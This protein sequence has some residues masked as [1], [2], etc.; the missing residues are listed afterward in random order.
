MIKRSDSAKEKKL[1]KLK[2]VGVKKSKKKEKPS[3]SIES[4]TSQRVTRS[5][6]TVHLDAPRVCSAKN[7]ETA[8][9]SVTKIVEREKYLTRSSKV[10]DELTQSNEINSSQNSNVVTDSLKKNTEKR[11]VKRENFV[12]L[13]NFEEDSFCL[14]K[15][16]F[17][18]PWP[19]RVL[20]IEKKKNFGAFLWRQT[21][22]LR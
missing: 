4:I 10:S 11:I 22:W 18:I 14:A 21:S 17:S 13:D 6:K 3:R 7:P 19:A 15:Q 9:E 2:T 1:K 12:K 16:K 5:S 20:K 8:S